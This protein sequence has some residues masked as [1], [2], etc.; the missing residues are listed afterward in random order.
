[1]GVIVFY[2]VGHFG[3]AAVYGTGVCRGVLSWYDSFGGGIA[4]CHCDQHTQRRCCR[5]IEAM[6][7]RRGVLFKGGVYVENAAYSEG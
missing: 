1:M 5:A 6:G 7:A 2:G 3:A 4:L